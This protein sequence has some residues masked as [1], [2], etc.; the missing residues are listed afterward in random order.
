MLFL[1]DCY[2]FY[3]HRQS[4]WLS[5]HSTSQ[6]ISSSVKRACTI[7]LRGFRLLEIR[8]ACFGAVTTK[9]NLPICAIGKSSP[10]CRN[11]EVSMDTIEAWLELSVSGANVQFTWLLACSSHISHHLS[12][13]AALFCQKVFVCRQLRNWEVASLEWDSLI[14]GRYFFGVCVGQLRTSAADSLCSWSGLT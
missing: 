3:K 5:Y 12:S 2:R 8:E 1:Y 11:S 13:T 10:C 9:A 14:S 7:H 4:S 6:R